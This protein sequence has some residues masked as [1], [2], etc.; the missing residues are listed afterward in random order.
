MK[1]VCQLPWLIPV[2]FCF[3]RWLKCM[4]TLLSPTL[5]FLLSCFLCHHCLHGLDTYYLPPRRKPHFPQLHGLHATF[6]WITQYWSFICNF[7][8]ILKAFLSI[9]L[10]VVGVHDRVSWSWSPALLSNGSWLPVE[11]FC[12]LQNISCLSIKLLSH[13]LSFKTL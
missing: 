5:P 11:N 10:S 7:R 6:R 1:Y 12:K 2:R 4:P 3:E 8:G 9:P 13:T